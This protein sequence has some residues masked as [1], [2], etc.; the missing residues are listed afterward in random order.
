MSAANTHARAPHHDT[1]RRHSAAPFS[2]TAILPPVDAPIFDEHDVSESTAGSDRHIYAKES[3]SGTIFHRMGRKLSAFLPRYERRGTLHSLRIPMQTE[4]QI[5]RENKSDD[6]QD[7]AMYSWRTLSAV[8]QSY[9]TKA[10]NIYGTSLLVFLGFHIESFIGGGPSISFVSTSSNLG[11]RHTKRK[12]A[13]IFVPDSSGVVNCC[14][15]QVYPNGEPCEANKYSSHTMRS[16]SYSVPSANSEQSFPSSSPLQHDTNDEVTQNSITLLPPIP[17]RSPKRLAPITHQTTTVN[18]PNRIIQITNA[19]AH[20]LSTLI[21]ALFGANNNGRI[22]SKK[23]A[24]LVSRTSFKGM[25][26]KASIS[27]SSK[28]IGSTGASHDSNVPNV[29][30]PSTD[31][32]PRNFESFV[33]IRTKVR[34]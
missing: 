32:V 25:K 10:N 22:Q 17:P 20:S 2:L 21:K 4:I 23:A 9:Q 24:V 31:Y 7:T 8:G 5:V 19:R 3:G 26:S 6:G 11:R 14:I 28:K 29:D 27:I 16:R 1:S 13:P 12:P 34:A 15:E 33:W 30:Q 18:P